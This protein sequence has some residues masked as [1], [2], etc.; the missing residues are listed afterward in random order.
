METIDKYIAYIQEKKPRN[1]TRM[2]DG[3]RSLKERSDI[4][5]RIDICNGDMR[6]VGGNYE[7]R[8]NIASDP[9]YQMLRKAWAHPDE[10]FGEQRQQ[11]KLKYQNNSRQNPQAKRH[12]GFF[13]DFV[14]YEGMRKI[15]TRTMDEGTYN[16]FL[17]NGL[18][19]AY[20]QSKLAMENRDA[21][22]SELREKHKSGKLTEREALEVMALALGR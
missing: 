14:F 11:K 9:V 10:A 19:F 4:E 1:W 21:R 12:K 18:M 17:E 13:Q 20:E 16:Q 15:E 3:A 22:R 6:F 8:S 7:A 2:L 5:N